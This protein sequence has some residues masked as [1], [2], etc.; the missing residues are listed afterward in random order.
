MVIK[1]YPW[2]LINLRPTPGDIAG[3]L[4]LICLVVCQHVISRCYDVSMLSIFMKQLIF[5]SCLICTYLNSPFNFIFLLAFCAVFVVIWG[6]TCVRRKPTEI[7]SSNLRWG[8]TR[9]QS[10]AASLVMYRGRRGMQHGIC[11][12]GVN[13][14]CLLWVVCDD[15]ARVWC[16]MRDTTKW[17]DR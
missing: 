4:D 12:S 15:Q 2:P 3:L 6:T 11:I 10:G 13:R 1:S 17:V 5:S 8:D 16:D 7:C 14:R 9:E